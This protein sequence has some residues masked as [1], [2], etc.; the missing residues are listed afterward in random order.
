MRD[1]RCLEAPGQIQNSAE[2]EAVPHITAVKS[3]VAERIGY[4]LIRV[5]R[6]QAR[7]RVGRGELIAVRKPLVEFYE[8]SL[9]RERD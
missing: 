7:Q 3:E 5:M 9:A 1:Q 6:L 2:G 4:V 8:Q